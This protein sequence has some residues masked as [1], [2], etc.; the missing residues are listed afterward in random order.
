MKKSNRL[1]SISGLEILENLTE[2]YISHNAIQE[3][4]GLEANTKLRVLDISNN[5]VEQLRGLK[6][7]H[8]L[9]ELWASYNHINDFKEIESELSDLEFLNTVYFE[10]N[11]VQKNNEVT[12]RNKL[13]IILT[14]LKQID[15]TYC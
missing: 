13:K 1:T 6:H 14:H 15:A 3:I 10:G 12:Y 9:E 8:K 7:L 11:P 5:R 4:S 2:L